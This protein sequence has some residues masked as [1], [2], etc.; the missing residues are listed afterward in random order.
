MVNTSQS[1]EQ[2]VP[3]GW[4]AHLADALAA[5][6]REFAPQVRDDEVVLLQVICLPWHGLLSLAMLTAEE[7]AE[8]ATLADPMRTMD[9]K[10]GEFT[11]EVEAWAETTPL[12]QAMRAAYYS[13]DDCPAAALAFLRGC[14]EAAATSRVIEAVRLF[15]RAEGFRVSVP[16]P[17][18]R[19]E[20]YPPEGSCGAASDSVGQ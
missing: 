9:W 7:L 18:N 15:R 11:E 20:F 19:S 6:L 17:D 1:S 3:D 12:A 10:Y 2:W 16:H 5:T 8:D 14:A 13:S 4:T